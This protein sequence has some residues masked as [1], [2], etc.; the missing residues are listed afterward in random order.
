MWSTPSMQRTI[1]KRAWQCCPACQTDNP[2][3]VLIGATN[4]HGSRATCGRTPRAGY[5]AWTIGFE[6]D[7]A[8]SVTARCMLYTGRLATYQFKPGPV[9]LTRLRC[10]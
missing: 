8:S 6:I 10:V 7:A 5:A 2:G 3:L 1:P 4:R 9:V